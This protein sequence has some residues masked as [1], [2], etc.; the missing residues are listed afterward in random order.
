MA[1]QRLTTWLLLGVA[2]CTSP[3]P[4]TFDLPPADP[5]MPS[6]NS[7]PTSANQA[8]DTVRPAPESFV[9]FEAQRL[10]TPEETGVH[11]RRAKPPID[12]KTAPQVLPAPRDPHALAAS[13]R[14]Y[15][16]AWAAQIAAH[17]EWSPEEHEKRR[18]ILKRAHLR[19]E[20]LR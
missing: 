18:E 15:L 20:V 16:D 5:A 8:D 12:E 7:P 11:D 3:K 10:L 2:A 19:E 13:Q 6:A 17:P 1:K 9:P 14:A 4:S